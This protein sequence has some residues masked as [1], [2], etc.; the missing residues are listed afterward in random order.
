MLCIHER[1]TRM[2]EIFAIT[3]AMNAQVL[4]TI[5]VCPIRSKIWW[6]S[7]TVANTMSHCNTLN[8]NVLLPNSDSLGLRGL[9]DMIL[10][11][12][13]SPSKIIEHAGSIISSIKTT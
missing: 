12:A 9:R 11:S 1:L 2:R 8:I 10:S 4:A 6:K 3:R 13:C 7:N 5:F